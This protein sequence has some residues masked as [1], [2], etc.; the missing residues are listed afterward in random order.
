M[1]IFIDT[2]LIYIFCREIQCCY[3]V[4]VYSGVVVICVR[5]YFVDKGEVTGFFYIVEDGWYNLQ[6]IVRIGIFNVVDFIFI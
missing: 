3:Y 6:V 5:D 4:F 2:G 1:Q